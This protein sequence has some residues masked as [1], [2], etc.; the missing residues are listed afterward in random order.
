MK[1][2]QA[3]AVMAASGLLNQVCLEPDVMCYGMPCYAFM[4][5]AKLCY[6]MPYC[7]VLCC[8]ALYCVELNLSACMEDVGSFTG[9]PR[10]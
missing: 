5:C 8:I 7:D 9:W 4:C 1:A 2:S 6:A 3:A 10:G